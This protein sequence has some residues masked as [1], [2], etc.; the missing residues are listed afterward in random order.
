MSLEDIADETIFR[1]KFSPN[2]AK[3]YQLLKIA[4]ANNR[5]DENYI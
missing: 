4:S 5:V 2:F 1:F 3:I